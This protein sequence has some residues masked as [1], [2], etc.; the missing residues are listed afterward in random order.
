MNKVFHTPLNNVSA[1]LGAAYTAGSG[2]L[3]LASGQGAQFGTPSDSAPVRFTVAS[4]ADPT[5]LTIFRATGRSTDALT[6]VSA[7]EGTTDRDYSTG[8]A[9][10]VRATAGSFTDVHDAIALA[11]P[12]ASPSFTGTVTLPNTTAS[13]TGVVMKGTDRFIHDFV[14]AGGVGDNTFVGARAG[15]FTMTPSEGVPYAAAYN[16]GVGADALQSN[17]TGFMNVAVGARALT[18]NTTGSMCVAIGF[19]ALQSNTTGIA[20]VSIGQ[21]T[22]IANTT[23]SYNTAVGTDAFYRATTGSYNT[24]C[25]NSSLNC[26]VVGDQNTAV[27]FMAVSGA[28]EGANF[29]YNTGVGYRTL[30]S[31]TTGQYN[32]SLGHHSLYSVTTG[33]YNV[34]VGSQAGFLI[35]SGN[36]NV[37]LG[38]SALQRTTTGS[39]NVAVGYTAMQCAGSVTTG[40]YNV[41]VGYDSATNITSGALNVAVGNQSLRGVTVANCNTVVGNI[42]GQNLTGSNNT[43]IGNSAAV[44]AAGSTGVNNVAVGVGSLYGVSSGSKNTAVGDYTGFAVTTGSNNAFLGANAGRYETTASN[45]LIIDVLDRAN[46]SDSRTRALVYAVA[47]A[48]ASAQTMALNVGSLS[49]L[50]SIGVNGATPPAKAAAP[51]TLAEVITI[52]RNMGFCA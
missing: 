48:T 52:L 26:L 33:V 42:A 44:G 5:V 11:A 9:V 12:L 13:G 25:G 50:G 14:P 47:N 4:Q 30:Y 49:V 34:G 10:E 27:G 8:D 24:G 21:D 28:S 7:I 18:V 41:A 51:T 31:L 1:T 17:T 6:G 37:A 43:A 22:L 40:S 29:S 16:V 20:N 3:V 19:D 2:S 46:Q 23:G 38:M 45:T 35:S 32:S 36:S 15:N 39:Y